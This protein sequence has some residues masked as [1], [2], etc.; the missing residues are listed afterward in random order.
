MANITITLSKI[1]LQVILQALELNS[2]IAENMLQ[3]RFEHEN[4]DNTLALI[5]YYEKRKSLLE[6][7]KAKVETELLKL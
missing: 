5:G 7:L 1:E 2:K 6:P 3:T 4:T